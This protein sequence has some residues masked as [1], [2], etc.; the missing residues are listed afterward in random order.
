MVS[1]HRPGKTVIQTTNAFMLPPCIPLVECSEPRPAAGNS[2][3][4]PWTRHLP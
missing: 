4:P 1:Q 3:P 2:Q